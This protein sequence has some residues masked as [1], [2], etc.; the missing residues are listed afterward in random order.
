MHWMVPASEDTNE[1]QLC[2]AEGGY[3]SFGERGMIKIPDTY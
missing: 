2:S 3:E 1:V